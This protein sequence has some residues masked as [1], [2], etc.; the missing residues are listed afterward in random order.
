MARD[1]ESG[2]LLGHVYTLRS[3]LPVRLR[4]ARTS[5]A[6][7]IRHLLERS[8][9]TGSD[10]EPARLVH[11]DPRRRYVLCATGLVEK[12]ETLL[13]VGAISLEAGGEPDL[14]L[15]AEE[16]P[17]ELR[18]LLAHALVAC[19]HSRARAA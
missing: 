5:D 1:F 17:Q 9:Y 6:T 7:A 10:L 18:E 2:A 11:F 12:T 14:L 3:G 4:L 8:G 15:V 16:Q 13:G 19:A